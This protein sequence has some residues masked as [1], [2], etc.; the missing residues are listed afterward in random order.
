MVHCKGMLIQVAILTVLGWGIGTLGIYGI[1]SI[2]PNTMPFVLPF[3]LI[4][5]TGV[6]FLSLNIIGSMLSVFKVI[7]ADALEAIGRVE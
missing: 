1:K 4:L 3:K 6:V 2:L 5:A 7:K